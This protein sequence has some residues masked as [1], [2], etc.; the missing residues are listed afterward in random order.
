MPCTT[1]TIDGD[2]RD[3]LYELVRNHLGAVGDLWIAL[4]INKD[5]ATAERLGLKFGED[6]RLL[7]DIG[8]NGRDGRK[9]FELTMPPEDLMNCSNA[10]TAKPNES[11]SNRSSSASQGKKTP[12]P[13]S[14]SGLASMLARNC[15][16]TSTHGRRPDNSP[17]T[18]RLLGGRGAGHRELRSCLRS[19]AASRTLPRPPR[20]RIPKIIELGALSTIQA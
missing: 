1:C 8:W 3:G 14:C 13:T 7:E 15:W 10:F 11:S 16:P 18:V 6:F 19:R 2:Q 17:Q 4:E 20:S 5:F 9:A 12:R